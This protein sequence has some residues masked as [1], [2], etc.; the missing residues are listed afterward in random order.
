MTGEDIANLTFEDAMPLA[1]PPEFV[2]C[3]LMCQIRAVRYFWPAWPAAASLFTPQ[4]DSCS[5]RAILDP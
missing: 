3:P 2:V 1:R 5:C 4:A